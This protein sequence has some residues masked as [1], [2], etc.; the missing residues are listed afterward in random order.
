ML[1]AGGRA[2]LAPHMRRLLLLTPLALAVLAMPALA[3]PTQDV[4]VPAAL[5][6][7]IAAVKARTDV[8]VRLPA[9]MTVEQGD[10]FPSGTG[11]RKGWALGLDAAPDCGGANACFVASFSAQ[12]GRSA[13]SA[14]GC[15]AA[16]SGASSRSAA[17]RR[18]RR[19]RSSGSRA[20]PSTRSRPAWAPGRRSGGCSS[21]WRTRRSC[22]ARAEGEG[23][24]PEG[25]APEGAAPE[26]AAPGGR[27]QASE[28][29]S[30]RACAATCSVN[31]A[32][33]LA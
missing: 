8:P 28:R 14:C 33:S 27:A 26:G 2:S 1:R 4:D 10:L 9:E 31:A 19:R 18:A 13:P 22:T 24:A 32:K 11:D 5:A 6:G 12:R 25:A 21:A 17:A 23:A 20:P 15:A 3:A 30:S 29:P 7:Q 16:G